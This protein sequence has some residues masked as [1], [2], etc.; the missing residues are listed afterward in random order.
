MNEK[1]FNFPVQL[2][3]NFVMDHQKCL[4]NVL[5]YSLY[6][7]GLKLTGNQNQRIKASAEYFGVSLGNQSEANERGSQLVQDCSSNSPMTGISSTVFWNYCG[8]EKTEW[9]KAILLAFLAMKSII[10]DKQ[11]IKMDNKFWLS[12][13]AGEKYSLPLDYLPPEIYKYANEYQTKK[14]KSELSEN[15]GLVTYSRYTRGFYISFKMTLKAL[16]LEA[17]TRRKSNRV[18]KAKMEREEALKEVLEEIGRGKPP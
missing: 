1:Y 11:F 12:R 17:E 13:M 18:L 9:D 16:I 10:G 2:L 7:Q 4:Q 5:Y 6:K 8:H 3:S 15:W 14:L